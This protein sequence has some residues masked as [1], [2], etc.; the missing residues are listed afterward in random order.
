MKKIL[1]LSILS[2]FIC[3]QAIAK[4]QNVT[5]Y[6]APKEMVQTQ[7]Y[8]V[9][10]KAYQAKDFTTR[11][12]IISFWSK[13]CAPCIRGLRSLNQF[14]QNAKKEKNIDVLMLSSS[15][16]WGKAGYSQQMLNKFGGINLTSYIDKNRKLAKKLGVTGTPHMIII[17]AQ[18]QEIARIKGGAKWDDPKVV[19]Y[20]YNIVDNLP[21]K[22]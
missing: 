5:V 19:E 7:F 4:E 20:I 8:D 6:K 18:G 3:Q 22:S 9:S 1:L 17:N 14:S 10:G 11:P 2:F 15:T 16:E 12:T 21:N 13:D